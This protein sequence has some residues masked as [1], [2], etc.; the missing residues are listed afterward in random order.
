MWGDKP[1]HQICLSYLVL[2]KDASQIPLDGNF[3]SKE[4]R[5]DNKN[6]TGLFVSIMPITMDMLRRTQMQKWCGAAMFGSVEQ[7]LARIWNAGIIFTEDPL[8]LVCICMEGTFRLRRLF[9]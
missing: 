2:L 9:F 4:Y 5:E 1:C 8:G 3:V 7:Y 6:A